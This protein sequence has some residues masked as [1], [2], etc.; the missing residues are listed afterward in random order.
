MRISSGTYKGRELKTPKGTKTR[1]TSSKVRESI[2]SILQNEIDRARFLDLF[3]GSGSMGIEALS[4][5]AKEATFVEQ[6]RMA[7][8]CIREN[9]KNLELDA[10][11]IQGDVF[12]AARRLVKQETVFD[13]IYVDPPYSLNLSPLFECLPSLLAPGGTLFI[14]QGKAAEIELIGLEKMPVRH[15]GDTSVHPYCALC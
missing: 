12:S 13:I 7:A 4:R 10:R 15:F 11:L 6:D 8:R 5:G 1:P 3:A 2:F 14:E 9:L